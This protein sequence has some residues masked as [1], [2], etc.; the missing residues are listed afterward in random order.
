MQVTIREVNVENAP[1]GKRYQIAKVVY[2]YRGENRNTQIFSFKNPSVFNILKDLPRNTTV[3]VEITQE[4]QYKNWSKVTP[5]TADVV[6]KPAAS[7]GRVIGSNYETPAERAARQV[8]IVRQSS[9]SSAVELLKTGA[10]APPTTEE[11]LRVAQEFVDFVFQNE[12]VETSS[13]AP[14]R[15]AGMVSE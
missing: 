12:S 1:N 5:V 14:E 3:D 4:G 6:E 11:V 9:I 7:T 8:Y 2:D 10:K 15:T 13:A